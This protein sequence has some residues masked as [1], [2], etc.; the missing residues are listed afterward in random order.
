MKNILSL[1]VGVLF[2]TFTS[3]SQIN[4]NMFKWDSDVDSIYMTWN[5]DTPE[6]EMK[7]DIKALAEHGITVN[8]SNVKRNDKNEIIAIDVSFDSKTGEKGS[9]SYNNSKPISTIK[10]YKQDDTVGFGEPSSSFENMGFASNFIDDD[11]LMESFKFDSPFI[12]NESRMKT[13][14][15]IERT[16][17]ERV[18]IENGK[19]VEGGHDYTRAELNE[20]LKSVEENKKNDFG[21]NDFKRGTPGFMYSFGRNDELKNE[22]EILKEQVNKILEKEDLD[23]NQEKK[24]AKPEESKKET[25]EKK[26][27][28]KVKKA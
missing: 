6:Q 5:K 19:V 9:L 26:T 8:Y 25:K 12:S 15:T 20:L 13:I 18:V 27:S 23:N 14:T 17:K 11:K 16:G 10:I 1:F 2:V 28:L 4:N 24:E 22:I 21:S 3:Y 7:D